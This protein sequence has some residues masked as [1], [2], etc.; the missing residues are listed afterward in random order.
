MAVVIDEGRPEHEFVTAADVRKG[1]QELYVTGFVRLTR[2]GLRQAGG[3][4]PSRYALTWLPTLA[5]SPNEL[6]PTHEWT[7]VIEQLHQKKIGTVRSVR[8]WL[9]RETEQSKRGAAKRARQEATPHLQVVSPA[10]CEA[11]EPPEETFSAL[12]CK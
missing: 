3:G 4:E 10:N 12:T 9:K 7:K 2:Q 8:Q 1:L 6:P 11:M 5:A